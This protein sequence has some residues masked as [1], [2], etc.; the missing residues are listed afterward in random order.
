LIAP[1]R[2]NTPKLIEV[3]SQTTRPAKRL[4]GSDVQTIAPE[5]CPK[6]VASSSDSHMFSIYGQATEMPSAT[7]AASGCPSRLSQRGTRMGKQLWRMAKPHCV[8]NSQQFTQT[9][10]QLSYHSENP[11]DT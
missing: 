9:H 2:N 3:E 11:L 7:R 10:I 6:V 8:S 4:G 1:R 5:D